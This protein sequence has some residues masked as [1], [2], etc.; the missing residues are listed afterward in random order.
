MVKAEKLEK[1]D[2]SSEKSSK[3]V[4]K[5]SYSKKKK[6]TCQGSKNKM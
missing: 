2:Q 6:V 1:K 3:K 4:N 5:S